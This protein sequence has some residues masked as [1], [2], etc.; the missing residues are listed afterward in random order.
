MDRFQNWLEETRQEI[1]GY[2]EE[3]LRR[4]ES[5]VPERLLDAMKY[6]VFGGGKRVRP[7]L[8]FAAGEYL[9]MD[10]SFLYPV[11]GAIEL[12]HTYS[13]IH[14]DLP[15]MDDDDYRRGRLTV[16]RKFDEATA[17]LAGD[18]LLTY[19]FEVIVDLDER[20]DS[21]NIVRVVRYLASASGIGGMVSG[22]QLD[23]EG[24]KSKYDL[25]QVKRMAF[26]KTGRL[27]QASV[28]SPFI[29]A[30]REEKAW[31]EMAGKMGLLFQVVDDILDVVGD[32]KKVG[33]RLRKD[34][35]SGKNTFVSVLGLEGAIS[36]RNDLKRELL[37]FL[38]A[39]FNLTNL[40]KFI[41]ERDY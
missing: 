36:L 19:A 23:M 41:A 35:E 20:F 38:P 10:H 21:A 8:V 4:Q 27:I 7:L 24:E 29:L 26:L 15:A 25:E 17:I 31:E 32:E 11:A 18:A 3:I 2:L 22:Q 39:G 9:Q 33:K 13:L 12:I 40:V 6:A 30:G 37:E 1:N 34:Q 5:E 16:H 28:Y 14:D